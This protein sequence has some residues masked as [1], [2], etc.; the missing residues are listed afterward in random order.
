MAL[1]T[2]VHK[3]RIDFQNGI[4]ARI[5]ELEALK[6]LV[7]RGM[8]QPEAMHAIRSHAHKIRGVAA[9]LGFREL[10]DLSS[11]LEDRISEMTEDQLRNLSADSPHWQ[12]VD[13]YFEAM[14][15]EMEHLL[16]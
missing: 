12:Q 9:T 6:V 16:P 15:D 4:E 2:A 8:Q 7:L 5:I 10:S 13:P 11:H 1:H 3:I 14:L